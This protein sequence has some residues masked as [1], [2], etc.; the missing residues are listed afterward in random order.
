MMFKKLLYMEE[1]KQKKPIFSE[2]CERLYNRITELVKP[3]PKK[4]SEIASLA[5]NKNNKG[6]KL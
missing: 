1:F 4:I 5:E 2:A 6:K 3:P